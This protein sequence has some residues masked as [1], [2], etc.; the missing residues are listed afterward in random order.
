M[1][2]AIDGPAGVGK[3]SISKIIA[4][5][6]GFYYL[7]SGEF[8]RAITYKILKLNSKDEPIDTLISIAYSCD[9]KIINNRIHLDGEDVQNFLHTPVLDLETSKISSIG[10]I[11]DFVNDLIYKITDSLNIVAE[12]RD[13]TT[14]VFPNAEYKFYLDAEPEIRAKRRYAQN[15]LA[16]YAND[17]MKTILNNLILRDKNDKN[18]KDGVIT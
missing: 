1:I 3:S 9:I 17:S 8:Y 12:G 10:K 11:R 18:K 7:N 6:L 13:M 14:V 2:I 4:D 5:K 15:N 16:G